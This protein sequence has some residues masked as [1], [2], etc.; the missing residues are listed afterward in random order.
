M[1]AHSDILDRREPFGKWWLASAGVHGALFAAVA[2]FGLLKMGGTE[3]WGEP[4]SLGGGAV[5][6][7]PVNRI[8][9]QARDGRVNPV[10]NDTEST[11]PS[12]AAER[13]RKR[14]L[15]DPD[16]IALKNSKAKPEKLQTAR[17]QTYD[18][19]EARPNQVYSQAGQA[20]TSPMF[21]QAQG[22]GGVGSGSVSPFGNRF[23]YYEQLL[24]DKVARNWKSEDLNAQIKTTA[25][26]EFEILRNGTVRN[27]RLVR[28]SG[29]FALDQSAQ[30]AIVQSNP[31]PPLPAGFERDSA[32]I[33]FSFRLQK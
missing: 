6:I 10:A 23:G 18:P 28:T 1:A 8:P 11:V 14:N 20:A 16:A 29:D 3:R 4:K 24:R 22:G 9:I 33:E 27:V 12:E 15:P 19:K 26:V 5:G 13:D 31:F 2:T 25:V 7:T 30:R 21:S 32:I 17:R